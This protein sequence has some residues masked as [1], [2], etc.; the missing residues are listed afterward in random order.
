LRF[1]LDTCLISELVRP[2]PD[3]GVLNW[4]AQQDESSLFL[5]AVSL[6]ELKR[7]IEKLA[8]GKRKTFLHQ[9]LTENVIQR[10]GDRILP[11]GADVC[12]RWG[13]TQAQLEKLGQPMPAI[14]GLIA[15]IALQHQ[16]TVVTRNTRDMQASGA[17]LIN[18]WVTPK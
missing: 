2:A 14:D 12:L 1:L 5:A 9:W 7:G 16:L 11:L 8:A 4:I 6:G 13:E 18:P 10:F 3:P 17:A 15:A